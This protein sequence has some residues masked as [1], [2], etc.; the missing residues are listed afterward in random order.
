MI[1]NIHELT[2]PS[3]AIHKNKDTLGKN[4]VRS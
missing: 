4:N 1:L 3:I 2:I